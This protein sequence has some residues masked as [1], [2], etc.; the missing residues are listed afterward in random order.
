MRGQKSLSLPVGFEFAEDLLSFTCWP[1]RH[2]D[3]VVQALVRAMVSVRGQCFD[4]IDV[5]V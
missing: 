3:R 4:R 2:F 1:V 5:A